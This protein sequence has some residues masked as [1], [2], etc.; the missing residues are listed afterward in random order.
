MIVLMVSSVGT[1]WNILIYQK[2]KIFFGVV[3]H[4]FLIGTDNDGI[5]QTSPMNKSA[6][7]NFKRYVAFLEDMFF[8]IISNHSKFQL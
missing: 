7:H 4:F 5:E 3:K 2:R 8:N 1:W 6:K